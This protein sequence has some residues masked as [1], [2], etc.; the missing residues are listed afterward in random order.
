MALDSNKISNIQGTKIPQWIINQLDTRADRGAQTSRD[1]ENLLFLANKTAWVR[2]VSSIDIQESDLRYFQKENRVGSS[3]QNPQDLAKQFVLF[4]GTSKYLR[5]NSYQQRAGLGKDGAYGILGDSEIQQFGYKPM[6]GITSATIETQ[7]KL[8][9]LRA[10]VINFKCWDKA[11]LDIIDALYFKLG[12]TMLLEWGHTFFYK[13]A[14]SKIESSEAYSIDPFKQNLTKEEIAVQISRNVRESEGNYDA[15]LGMVTNFNFVY[16]QDGG[17]DCTL[18]LM[19]LGILGDSLK[20][21]NQG[22]LPGI[23]KDELILLS[24]TLLEIAGVRTE[25]AAAAPVPT[26]TVYDNDLLQVIVKNRRLRT[27]IPPDPRRVSTPSFFTNLSK[28]VFST[29]SFRGTEYYSTDA[30]KEFRRD[31][32]SNNLSYIKI[33]SQTKL[34]LI[35]PN[36]DSLKPLD[37]YNFDYFFNDTQEGGN[38]YALGKLNIIVQENNLP[39]YQNI[40]LNGSVL[41]KLLGSYTPIYLKDLRK[42]NQIGTAGGGVVNTGYNYIINY[43]GESKDNTGNFN[44]YVLRIDVENQLKNIKIQKVGS[45]TPIDS[46]ILETKII[47]ENIS[48]N[49][50]SEIINSIK[51]G[52]SKVNFK[53]TGLNDSGFF[54]LS[55]DYPYVKEATFSSRAAGQS[56]YVDEKATVSATVKVDFTFS[57]SSL[58]TTIKAPANLPSLNLYDEA[59]KRLEEQNRIDT[60]AALAEQQR[61]DQE[62]L[63]TQISQALS[64][65]SSLELTL[66]TIQVHALNKA[67]ADK[68]LQAGINKIYTLNIYDTKD[69][70]G[71][72]PFYQQIFSDGIFSGFIENLITETGIEDDLLTDNKTTISVIDRLKIYSKYGFATELLAGNVSVKDL[73]RKEVDFQDLLKAYVVPYKINQEIVKGVSTN[74]PVYIPLGLLLMILNHNCGMYVSKDESSTQTPLVYIDFNPNLNFLLTTPKHLSTNPLKVLIPFEGTFEDYKSLFSPTILNNEKDPKKVAILPTSGSTESTPLFQFGKDDALSYFIPQLKTDPTEGGGNPYRGKLMNIL[75]NIDY[76]IELVRDYSLK[77]STNSVYLKTFLEQIIIDINK[78][79]GNFNSLRLSYNDRGNTFQIVDNQVIKPLA[80]EVLLT[81]DNTTYLP[82]EG[83]RSVAKTLE[84]K[85]DIST[86]L[87]SL[88]AISANT[89]AP[90]KATLSVNGDSVGFINTNYKDRYVSLRTKPTGSN[91]SKE[92]DALKGAASQFNKTIQDFYSVG[93]SLQEGN[94]SQV[95][96]YYIE[97]LTVVK[98]EDDATR[99]SALIPLSINIITDGIS[100]LTMG[101]AFTVSDRLLPYTYNTR[102]LQNKGGLNKQNVDKVGF[103]IVGL[104]NVIE[105]NQWN[106]QFRS[107]MMYLKYA[108]DF[109]TIKFTPLQPTEGIFKTAPDPGYVAAVK[110]TPQERE[111]A[112]KITKTFFEQKGFKPV[113][114]SAIIGAL[115]QE[116]QLDPKI[117]NKKGAFGIAQWLGDRKTKLLAKSANDTLEVQLN[118]IIEEF[119]GLER[120]AG[121]RLK[122]ATTLEEAIAAMASYERYKGV[123]GNATYQDVLAAVETGF[124]IGYSK[125]ILQRYYNI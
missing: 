12:F 81:P 28:D 38:T 84:I 34:N 71:G 97:N 99:A 117:T 119:N 2:L 125:D 37:F 3:L 7:G 120:T 23:L 56:S 13:H 54:T 18:R 96:N 107:I 39:N 110:R 31:A 70:V 100:G 42:A 32:K 111:S 76:V 46:S 5:E 45:N 66:R 55:V 57:D 27:F 6:P 90:N 82:L 102:T 98:N 65:Q 94:I 89:D 14:T 61:K 4:G 63:S 91:V 105:G 16:N 121:N 40:K 78:Y 101:Q 92:N 24:N 44:K 51:Q 62:A 52:D 29:I 74:H 122:A 19:A 26:S 123:S 22:V 60:A 83:I 59:A 109:D 87:S 79:T 10:A 118:Y 106:T 72:K 80:N 104:T 77:D 17:Y 115:L 35:N 68:K 33:P 88:I 43:S 108:R 73:K 36:I 86:R 103:A 69:N 48:D 15:M 21:N 50:V 85:T 112:I 58:F 20:I 8:G 9:S 75:L 67:D 11:Q 114:I 53:L 95:T 41:E 93:I 30:I 1:N 47:N 116:S 25:T 49:L 113:Q 124:R 64:S